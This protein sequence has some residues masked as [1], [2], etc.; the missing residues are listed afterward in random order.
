MTTGQC[1][2][3]PAGAIKLGPKVC[4]NLIRQDGW[5]VSTSERDDNEGEVRISRDLPTFLEMTTMS[6]LGRLFVSPRV[7]GGDDMILRCCSGN[8]GGV[9]GC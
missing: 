1:G 7:A 3:T 2:R 5:P 8:I 9:A 6:T 4:P